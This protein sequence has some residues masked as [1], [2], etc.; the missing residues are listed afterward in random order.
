MPVSV[1]LGQVRRGVAVAPVLE[2]PREQLLGGLLRRELEL[3]LLGSG[4]QQAR[5]ELEQGRDEYEELG[6]RLEVEL[7]LL[8][9]VVEVGD[10]DLAEL[11]LGERDLLAQ[12]DAHQEVEG[13][14][15]NVEVEVELGSGSHPREA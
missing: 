1:E 15:E 11:D 7:P 13:A 4:Q 14:G 5:L 8:L 3:V 6:R 2:H 10:H 12:D 9:D